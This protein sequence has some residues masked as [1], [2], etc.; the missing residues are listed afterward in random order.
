MSLA[1]RNITPPPSSRMPVSNE[2]RVRVDDLEKISAHVWPVSGG[3][4]C[5]PRSFL[6]T[7][8]SRKIFSKSASGSFSNDNKCFMVSNAFGIPSKEN[9]LPELRGGVTSFSSRHRRRA[10]DTKRRWC[11]GAA[12]FRHA[13]AVPGASAFCLS[14]RHDRSRNARQNRPPA[15]C[16]RDRAEKSGASQR[17]SVRR[18]G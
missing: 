12:I 2:T 7:T 1:L 10:R 3:A 18:P 11:D 5:W 14:D 8:A 16:P 13:R 4:A 17:S 6:T 15:K 9:Y